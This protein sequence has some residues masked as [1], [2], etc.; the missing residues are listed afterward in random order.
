MATVI[1]AP[2]DLKEADLL[3]LLDQAR[4]DLTPLLE[5]SMKKTSLIRFLEIGAPDFRSPAGV[6]NYLDGAAKVPG[7]DAPGNP[8]KRGHKY[9]IL[10]SILAKTDGQTIAERHLRAQ[11][12]GICSGGLLKMLQKVTIDDCRLGCEM[13]GLALGPP[14]VCVFVAPKFVSALQFFGRAMANGNVTFSANAGMVKDAAG[15]GGGVPTAGAAPTVPGPPAVALGGIA[16]STT[17]SSSGAA[18]TASSDVHDDGKTPKRGN[19][20]GK[21]GKGVEQ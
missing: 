20:G 8:F 18:S 5:S 21:G 2:S 7:S 17:S 10:G 12:S 4:Q 13:L 14:R 3:R 15:G 11:G 19:Q 9:I 16:T 6:K 1:F